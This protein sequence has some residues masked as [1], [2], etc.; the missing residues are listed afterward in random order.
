[1]NTPGFSL[2]FSKV[3]FS[4]ELYYYKNYQNWT[5]GTGIV[6]IKPAIS[7]HVIKSYI[8]RMHFFVKSYAY[9]NVCIF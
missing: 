9:F 3:T 6:V 4:Y 5:A 1:M 2:Y 8:K 7:D